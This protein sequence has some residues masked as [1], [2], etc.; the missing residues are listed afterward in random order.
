[1]EANPPL[2]DDQVDYV[3]V[4]DGSG[5]L[6]GYGG[7]ATK[8]TLP[9]RYPPETHWLRGGCTG[10]GQVYRMEVTALLEALTWIFNHGQFWGTQAQRNLHETPLRIQWYGD[11]EAAIKSVHRDPVTKQHAYARAGQIEDLWARF[12]WFE[13]FVRINGTHVGRDQTR[14]LGVDW[15]AS[16]C[17]VILK[18][19]D[20]ANGGDQ[21]ESGLLAEIKRKNKSTPCPPEQN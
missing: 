14:M 17:R 3:V 16:T 15:L 5:H 1:M 6:D 4:T 9:H 10:N 21:I 12:E 20:A 7:W 8:I 11:N 13:P 18:S 2:P 19:C